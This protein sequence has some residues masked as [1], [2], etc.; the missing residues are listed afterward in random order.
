MKGRLRAIMLTLLIILVC[1]AAGAFAFMRQPQF[2]TLPDGPRLER[3]RQS[4][5]YADGEFQN[6][7]ATPQITGD[8]S[9]AGMLFEYLFIPKERLKPSR[10][11]PTVKTDL[12]ALD[13]NRD[14]VIWLGHSS[15]FMQLGGKRILVDPVFSAYAS[16]LSFSTRAFD[17]TSIYSAEDMPEI[18]YLIISHDHWDHLDYPTV[19]ALRAKVAKVV[20]GLGVGAH[21]EH[22][23]FATEKILEADWFTTLEPEKD[24]FIHVLPARH[25]SG[26]GLKR[27]R[28]LW[29]ACMLEA[30]GR[31]VF[32]SGD[33]GY[34]P[35]MPEIGERFAGCD[36]AI[37]ENGQY[38]RNWQYIHMLPEETARAAQEIRA[39][40][41][42]PVHA[43][44]F[45]IANHTWD[46][47]FKRVT[48]AAEGA[49][50]R[51]L[52]PRIG[53][54]VWLDDEGQTFPAW[55]EGIE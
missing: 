4:P 19:T 26:R 20:C 54:T 8:S 29:I 24:F 23:G 50:L 5:H 36:L 53:E 47:P 44:K 33:G 55:W 46:D 17:G 37:L 1:L 35:H 21:L 10:A 13:I 27:N 2:G 38:D 40:A 25:F 31:R 14:V 49:A 7:V 48:E 3:I 51:V 12:A 41:L 11:L 15:F 28:T 22:W 45:S 18:D 34:G 30:A 52:T 16:P 39:R 9:F 42:L 43:G 6:L 32:Y